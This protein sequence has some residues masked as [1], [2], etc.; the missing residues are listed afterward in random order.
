MLKPN[1][2][3]GGIVDGIFAVVDPNSE[4]IIQ[5]MYQVKHLGWFLRKNRGWE[6][7][8]SEDNIAVEDAVLVS[9]ERSRANELVDLFD[10]A[11]DHPLTVKDLEN[12][13]EDPE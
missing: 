5:M 11:I 1:P 9:V 2:K 10:S 7:P 8:S 4:Q 6:F 3:L 12:Y 13:T